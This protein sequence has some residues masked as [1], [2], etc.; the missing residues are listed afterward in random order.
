MKFG[1][2]F[3]S[4]IIF[5][6]VSC[7]PQTDS[8]ADASTLYKQKCVICHGADGKLC[9]AGAKDLSLSTSDPNLTKLII[10]NGRGGMPQFKAV[11]SEEQISKLATYIEA[12]RK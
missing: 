7:A 11:L 4:I 9:A 2:L 5:T 3:F 8:N 6:L 1:F 12:F 10:A